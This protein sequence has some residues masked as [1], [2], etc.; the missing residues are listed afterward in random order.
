LGIIKVLV[1]K[2]A[3]KYIDS[4]YVFTTMKN[5][6]VEKKK[7]IYIYTVKLIKLRTR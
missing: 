7:I 6:E 1:M 5:E 2:W 3:K 4:R